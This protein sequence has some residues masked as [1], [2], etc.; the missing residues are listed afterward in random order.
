[1]LAPTERTV[2]E[3]PKAV[4]LLS[5]GLDSSATIYHVRSLG[6]QLYALSFDYQQRH[7]RELLAAK[8]IAQ[9]VGVV[10]HQVV[11]FDLRQWGGSALT[12]AETVPQNRSI[13]EMERGIPIT[14]VPARNTIF[15]A[16]ALSWAEALGAEAIFIGAH[17]QDY[18]GYP[19]CRPDYLAAMGEVYRLGTKVGREGKSIQLIAP[20][21]DLGKKA[22]IT[23]GDQY[24]VP[25]AL[26]YSCYLG[27]PLACGRCDSCQLRRQAFWDLGQEDPVPYQG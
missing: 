2:V 24:Q 7:Q 19:D 26:T 18:S 9:A 17:I 11:Q 21:I 10:T 12:G 6:Y 15:L 5:G 20:L 14:Y 22:I 25:W 3:Q 23:L 27:E 8:A 16:F 13:A 4:V 1:M